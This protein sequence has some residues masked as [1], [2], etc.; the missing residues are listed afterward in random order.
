MGLSLSDAASMSGSWRS[1][2]TGHCATRNR[3]GSVLGKRN[4]QSNHQREK[5][6]CV[7]LT[8]HLLERSEKVI[9][10]TAAADRSVD[11]AVGTNG[12]LDKDSLNRAL[13]IL[14]AKVDRWAVGSQS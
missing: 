11:S 7:S 5:R 12:E 6:R 4:R 8:R 13:C 9:Q 2:S 1:S 14:I 3:L 10:G